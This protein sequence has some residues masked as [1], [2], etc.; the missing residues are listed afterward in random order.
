MGILNFSTNIL[1]TGNLDFLFGVFVMETSYVRLINKA[2]METRWRTHARQPAP[3]DRLGNRNGGKSLGNLSAKK[4]TTF[5]KIFW[6]KNIDLKKY[7][8]DKVQENFMLI[9][10]NLL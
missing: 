9:T 6:L 4:T 2:A 5:R 8:C 3:H 10:N 7:F 1:N